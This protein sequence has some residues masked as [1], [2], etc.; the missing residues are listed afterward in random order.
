MK[1]LKLPTS[2]NDLKRIVLI[3]TRNELLNGG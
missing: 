2:V 1:I 3:E